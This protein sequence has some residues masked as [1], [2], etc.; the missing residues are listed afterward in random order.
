MT[1]HERVLEFLREA[2]RRFPTPEKQRH[3]ILLNL[4]QGPRG[5]LLLSLR[6]GPEWQT[7]TLDEADL[8]LPPGD[9]FDDIAKLLAVRAAVS[10]P[11]GC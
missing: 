6:I 7:F 3:A 9:V 1:T 2:H 5:A 8:N 4:D 11:D 10:K